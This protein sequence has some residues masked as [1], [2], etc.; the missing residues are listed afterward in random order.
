MYNVPDGV[1][2]KVVIPVSDKA[3]APL[4]SQEPTS[5]PKDAP[6]AP[7]ATKVVIALIVVEV[8]LSIAIVE[9]ESISCGPPFAVRDPLIHKLFHL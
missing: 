5:S 4:N 9:S 2:A 1:T 3:P 8:V 6:V 7:L